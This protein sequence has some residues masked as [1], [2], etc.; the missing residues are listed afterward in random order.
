MKYNEHINNT[1][2]S[3]NKR[4]AGLKKLAKYLTKYDKKILAE[5]IIMSRIRYL[6]PILAGAPKYLITTL[7]NK[8]NEVMR[9][10]TNN[11]WS[12]KGKKTHQH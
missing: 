6:L 4:M 12:I 7:Q 5:G 9:I 1:V 2:K 3:I 11:K 8:Q 10:V